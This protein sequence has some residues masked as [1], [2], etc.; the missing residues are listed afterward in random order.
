MLQSTSRK[1]T[2]LQC[3]SKHSVTG[4]NLQLVVVLQCVTSLP[5]P[6]KP[7]P[8]HT[9]VSACRPVAGAVTTPQ[10]VLAPPLYW[11]VNVSPAGQTRRTAPSPG[12][13][14]PSS[15]SRPR[16]GSQLQLSSQTQLRCGCYEACVTHPCKTFLVM[17]DICA[18]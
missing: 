6:C 16:V 18:A 3:G 17:F 13:P 1:A 15:A 11:P 7:P 5:R 8:A 2:I 12:C 4:C 9:P 14:A 10:P